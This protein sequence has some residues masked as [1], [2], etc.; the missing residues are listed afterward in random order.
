[1]KR[2]ALLI[3]LISLSAVV[4][5]GTAQKR[6]PVVNRPPTISEVETSATTLTSC[7]AGSFCVPKNRKTVSLLVR[8]TD[9]D[10][11]ALTYSYSITEGEILGHGASVTWKLEG[12]RGGTHLARVTV[13][14]SRG[15]EATAVVNV[16]VVACISCFIPDPPCPI[17]EVKPFRDVAYRGEPIVY[18]VTVSS[19]YFQARPDYVWTVNAGRILRGQH[20]PQIEVEATGDVE[21]SVIATVEVDGF[22]RACARG[23]S[24]STLIRP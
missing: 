18:D 23:A 3:A 7:S 6:K 13:T 10:G 21:E 16:N 5:S 24:A 15:G 11:D 22:D 20:T 4:R 1:M 17:V 12:V 8:A 2:M 19:G 9:S 14:D